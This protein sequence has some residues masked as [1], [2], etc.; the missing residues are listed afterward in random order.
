MTELAGS[1]ERVGSRNRPWSWSES[2]DG[3][4][5]G[6]G[7]EYEVRRIVFDVVKA[8]CARLG[9]ERGM[10]IRCLRKDRSSVLV[11]LPDGAVAPIESIYARFIEVTPVEPSLHLSGRA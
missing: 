3:A 5:P 2:L 8:R 7:R 4:Q 10:T 9:L 1:D 6:R 11:E